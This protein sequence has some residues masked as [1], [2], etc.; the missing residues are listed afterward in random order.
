[1]GRQDWKTS[2]NTGFYDNAPAGAVD[3]FAEKAGIRDGDDLRQVETILGAELH[4]TNLKILEVGAGQGR[5]VHWL[6]N[7]FPHAEITA[8]DHSEANVATCTNRFKG[9]LGRIKILRKN[10]LNLDGVDPV[11]LALWMFTGLGE[12]P[13]KLRLLVFRQLYTVLKPGGYL[14][15]DMAV[16]LSK[17]VST[18]ESID[19]FFEVSAPW[20]KLNYHI[21]TPEQIKEYAATAGL[22]FFR[23][24]IYRTS[25]DTQRYIALFRR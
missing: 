8:I 18:T 24:A 7:R 11:H 10:V 9:F 21:A 15:V 17:H 19:G 25:S 22:T 6:L 14:A 4:L 13:P 23:D 5:V 3:S 12:V 1:M 20:G 2:E 16:T